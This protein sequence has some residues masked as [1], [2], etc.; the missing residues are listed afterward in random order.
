MSRGTVEA[1]SPSCLDGD[2]YTDALAKRPDADAGG[3]HE[4]TPRH[5]LVPDA[6][7]IQRSPAADEHG[8]RSRR[9][10]LDAELLEA[11]TRGADGR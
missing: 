11:L 9:A 2:A 5:R 8:T 3:K 6:Y 7:A 10:N 4:C 1:I